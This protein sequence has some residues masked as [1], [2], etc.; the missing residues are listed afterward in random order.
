MLNHDAAPRMYSLAATFWAIAPGAPNRHLT[1]NGA[2][3]DVAF[4]S[5]RECSRAGLAAMLVGLGD[6]AA[7]LLQPVSA[8]VRAV[9][10]LSP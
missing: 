10:P 8:G 9:A 2:R 7:A 3:A 1:M 5:L 6:S 4:L